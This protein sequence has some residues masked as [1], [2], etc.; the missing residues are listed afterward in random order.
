[1][2]QSDKAQPISVPAAFAD[3]VF[4]P[5]RLLLRWNWKTALLSAC[6]RGTIFFVSNL[7]A[8]LNAAISAM[9]VEAALF[10]TLAGFYGAMAQTFRRAQPAWAAT[11]AVMI[12]MPVVNHTLE[13]V[14][15][16]ANDTE[17]I[18]AGVA[19]SISLSILSAMF[20]LF[21]MRRGVLIVG[22]ERAPLSDDLRR[23]PR[24]VFD[25]V[26]AVPRA[27][28]RTIFRHRDIE[29]RIEGETRRRGDKE[30]R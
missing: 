25:F 30:K 1:M 5:R 29:I 7:G 28:W 16:N 11:M 20:N 9:A 6:V 21:A 4:N 10:A 3:L 2:R 26:M 14:L 24:V 13:Y 19:T 12:L 22:D 27:L 15:H 17:K 18:A 23:M 8:G